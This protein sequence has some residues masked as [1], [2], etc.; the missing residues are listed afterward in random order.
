MYARLAIKE[1]SDLQAAVT[2]PRKVA[3]VFELEH[4]TRKFP[5]LGRYTQHFT[6]ALNEGQECRVE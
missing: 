5:P 2:L 1:Q 6:E 3:V 4:L